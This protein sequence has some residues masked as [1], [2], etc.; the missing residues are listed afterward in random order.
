LAR[1]ELSGLWRFG[2]PLRMAAEG[3]QALAAL[4]G[5]GVVYFG[6]EWFAENRTSSHHIAKR[7]SA[8]CP[9]LYVDSPGLRAPRAS[10]RDVR[11]LFAKVA[12]AMRKPTRVA[13]NLW[14]C[15]IPQVPFRRLPGVKTL[16]RAFGRWA[17]RRA[18][19]AVGFERVISWFVVPHPGFMAGTLRE[20]L[21][22]YYCID[23]YAALPGVDVEAITA[24]DAALTRRADQVFVAAPSLLAAK[25]AENPATVHSP[26][27]VDFDLFARATNPAT[28]VPERAAALRSPIIGFFGLLADWINIQL[29]A[30]LAKQRPDWTLLLV[31]HIGT[32]VTDLGG[33]P[34]VVFVG[35]Q[36]YETLPNW[37][38]AFDV[39]VIPYR[40]NRQVLN[41]NPLK[42]REYLATGKPVV[43]VPTPEVERF[44]SHVRLA[45]TPEAF[46]SEIEAAL[47]EDSPERSAARRESVRHMSWDARVGEVLQVVCAALERRRAS[48]ET[49]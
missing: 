27:G 42:L 14:H 5:I 2:G 33:L 38:K 16:N 31:G 29:L 17:L 37:A 25:T 12:Q 47:R 9:L 45:A 10:G 11:R 41:A 26:H 21:I 4:T 30:F 23:D 1:T 24:A 35:P 20:D 44:A 22:V 48:K 3:S 40:L 28:A 39:A 32:D 46:L 6:N 34:N 49:R 43:S 19:A 13:P 15:T 36:P 18:V 8:Y 7:L